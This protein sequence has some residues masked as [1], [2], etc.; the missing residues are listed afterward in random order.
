MIATK[1]TIWLQKLVFDLGFLT[2]QSIPL[3]CDNQSCIKLVENPISM[4]VPNMLPY[5]IISC[6]NK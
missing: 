3:Y 4:N 5:V 1:K 2:L 6:V